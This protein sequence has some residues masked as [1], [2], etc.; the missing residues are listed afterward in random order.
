MRDIKDSF[1][2]PCKILTRN[3]NNI[4]NK[5]HMKTTTPTTKQIDGWCD[6][7]ATGMEK[8]L[9]LTVAQRADYMATLNKRKNGF[10]KVAWNDI[11]PNREEYDKDL[12]ALARRYFAFK[13][14]QYDAK[15]KGKKKTNYQKAHAL[16]KANGFTAKQKQTLIDL[17]S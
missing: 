14:V 12:V 17:L 16:C 1:K 6:S 4:R 2:T 10:E 15:G 8:L 5:L 3:T 13:Q 7:V 11:L 9:G